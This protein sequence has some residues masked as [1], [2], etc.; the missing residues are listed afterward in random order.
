MDGDKRKRD[1]DEPESNA[2]KRSAVDNNNK[3]AYNSHGYL[4]EGGYISTDIKQSNVNPTS[5]LSKEGSQSSVAKAV[6]SEEKTGNRRLDTSVTE[7]QLDGD[8]TNTG[9]NT[10]GKGESSNNGLIP[11]SIHLRRSGSSTDIC[12]SLQ[13]KHS[14]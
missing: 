3:P 5:N 12:S 4:T 11:I 14:V 7:Q 6:P 10:V 9:V 8:K 1:G 13:I 2:V